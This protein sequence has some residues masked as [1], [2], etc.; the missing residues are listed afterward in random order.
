MPCRIGEIF[1]DANAELIE[2]I[3]PNPCADYFIV[4]NASLVK[5]YDLSGR[6]LFE[7]QLQQNE[8]RVDIVNL[9]NGIYIVELSNAGISQRQKLVVK[10]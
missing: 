3:L 1:S 4:S 5:V 9:L 8:T 10:K 7:K 2:P 6:L